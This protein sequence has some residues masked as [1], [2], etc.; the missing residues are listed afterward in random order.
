MSAIA[1]T[2]KKPVRGIIIAG[3]FSERVVLAA[4]AVPNLK[5]VKY[6]F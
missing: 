5:L 3:D 4:S 2:D 1:K 6:K